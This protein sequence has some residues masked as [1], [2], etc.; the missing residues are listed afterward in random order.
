[1]SCDLNRKFV[2]VDHVG[3]NLLVNQMESTLKT[4]L[5]WG[6]LSIGGWT[7]IESPTSGAFGG[8]FATLRAVSDPAYTD[9][10]VW[11]SARKDWVWETGM[12]S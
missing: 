10:Q 2:K 5:D 1:M 9:G 8:N 7:N 3:E 11:E 12:G 4:Y 6:L